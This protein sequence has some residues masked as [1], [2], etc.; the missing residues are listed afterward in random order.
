[1]PS[2]PRNGADQLQTAIATAQDFGV[3][4]DER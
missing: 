2:T 1:V 3:E 4:I